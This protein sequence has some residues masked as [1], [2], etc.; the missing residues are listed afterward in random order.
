MAQ[1]EPPQ[2]LESSHIGYFID[3][4]REDKKK[5]LQRLNL[6]K[7]LKKIWP[8]RADIQNMIRKAADGNDHVLQ[9]L[10]GYELQA[11]MRHYGKLAAEAIRSKSAVA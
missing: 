7:N 4:L 6:D 10:F 11:L 3:W 9:P 1:L 5:F 8:D 2:Q